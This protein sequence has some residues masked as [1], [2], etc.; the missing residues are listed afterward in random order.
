MYT[1]PGEGLASTIEGKEMRS[2]KEVAAFVIAVCLPGAALAGELFTAPMT[3]GEGK[4]LECRITNV[5]KQVKAVWIEVW[6]FCGTEATPTCA[7]WLDGKLLK[8]TGDSSTATLLGPMG[9][10]AI[11]ASNATLPGYAPHICRFTVH[12]NVDDYRASACS[13]VSPGAEGLTCLPAR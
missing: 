12:G 1:R 11:D 6:G 4:S 13:V 10:V 7:N 3:V 2:T 8:T 9:T 5:T